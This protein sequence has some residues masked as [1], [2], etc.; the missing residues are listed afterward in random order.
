MRPNVCDHRKANKLA[1]T[2]M[3]HY[4]FIRAVPLSY[5]YACSRRMLDQQQMLQQHLQPKSLN[6]QLSPLQ[7]FRMHNPLGLTLLL[8][9]AKTIQHHW[10]KAL[11]QRRSQTQVKDRG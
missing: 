2:A 1:D 6:L 4:L 9:A 11:K 5:C 7:H 10:N 8:I 3:L